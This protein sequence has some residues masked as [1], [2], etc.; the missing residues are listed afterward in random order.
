MNPLPTQPSNPEWER[1][2]RAEAKKVLNDESQPGPNKDQIKE[3]LADWRE[4]RP[5]MWKRL[6]GVV[7]AR[8]LALVLQ[9]RYWKAFWAY[10]KAGMPRTDAREQAAMEWLLTTPEDSQETSAPMEA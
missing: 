5:L 9:D 7:L 8:P 10:Q 2:I 1:W 4:N 3:L 6:H